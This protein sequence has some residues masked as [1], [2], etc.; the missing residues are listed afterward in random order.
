[1][2]NRTLRVL[3]PARDLSRMRAATTEAFK[4]AARGHSVAQ[5]GGGQPPGLPNHYLY[6]ETLKAKDAR[7]RLLDTATRLRTP[8]RASA[9]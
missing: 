1:M 7:Q 9:C 8:R 6:Q 3:D 5:G 4:A 2:A